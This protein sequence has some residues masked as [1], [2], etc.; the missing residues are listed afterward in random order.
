MTVELILCH[1]CDL[2]NRIGEV[3]VGAAARCRRCRRVLYRSLSNTLDR[4]LAFSLS[5]LLLFIVANSFPFLSME[6][7]GNVTQTTLA[8]GVQ[9]LYEQGLPGIALLV[10]FTTVIAPLVHLTALLYVL[11]PLKFR[12]RAPSAPLVF[13][14]LHGVQLWSMME[15]FLIGIL[16]SLTKL[17]DMANIVPGIALWSFAALIPIVAAANASLDP[18][19]VWDR[20]GGDPA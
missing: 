9:T 7:Q 11:L 17:A 2:L 1:D 13:R 19:W 10:L 5:G 15:V 8:S 16:V 3:P 14:T 12:V 4:T 18:H 20:I 6:M